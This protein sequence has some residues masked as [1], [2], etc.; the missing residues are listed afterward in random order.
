MSCN[1]LNY[2]R[3]F[4]RNDDELYLP[5]HQYGQL[6]C[7]LFSK[8]VGTEKADNWGGQDGERQLLSSFP[9]VSF[10]AIADVPDPNDIVNSQGFCKSGACGQ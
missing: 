3:Y 10:L 1:M 2:R 8:C 9:T 6:S 4:D 5:K 7:A